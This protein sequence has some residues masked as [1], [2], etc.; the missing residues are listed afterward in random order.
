[1]L[2][3]AAQEDGTIALVRHYV[4]TAKPRRNRQLVALALPALKVAADT[5]HDQRILACRPPQEVLIVTADRPRQAVVRTVQVDGARLA[6]V[7]RDDGGARTLL[8]R[9][10]TPQTGDLRLEFLPAQHVRH[11]RRQDA[12]LLAVLL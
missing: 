10:R 2:H 5:Q 8:G 11:E 9:Q 3:P 1:M 6:V 12:P 4:A 7:A